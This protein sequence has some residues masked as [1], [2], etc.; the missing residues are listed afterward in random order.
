MSPTSPDWAISVLAGRQH[1]MVARRQLQELGLGPDAIDH[2]VQGG[3]LHPSHR[4]VYAVGHPRPIGRARWMAAVLA[5]GPGAVLSHASAAAL[6]GLRPTA[7]TR[8]DVTVPGRRGR[9]RP[10]IALHRVR[11]LAHEDRATR[12]GIPVTAVART[13]LDLAEVAPA[14]QLERAVEEAQRLRL[15][16][17]AAIQGVCE[18]SH[19]RHGLRAL[20]AVLADAREPLPVRSELERRFA[21]LCEEADLPPPAL[22]VTVAGFEVDAYWPR[23]RLIVELDGFAYHRSRAAFERDRLRDADLQLAGYRV[24]RITARRLDREPAAIAAALRMLLT[25]APP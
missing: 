14:P 24:L 19:G 3:R 23:G 13:L 22:N 1:G 2:R 10:G 15:L 9:G 25:A 4:G 8:I 16:D 18:R 21:R 5:G 12:D 17:L 7:K 6:W 11:G 20:R